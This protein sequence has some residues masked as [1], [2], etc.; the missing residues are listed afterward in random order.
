[1]RYIDLSLIDL[2]NPDVQNWLLKAQ[3]HLSALMTLQTHKERAEYFKTHGIWSDFKPNLVKL[4]GKKCWYSECLIEGD[5]GDVDHFRPKNRS[6]DASGKV[7]L[8]DGYWWLAYDYTNYRLSCSICNQIGK[9]DYFP[10][11]PGSQS[12][13]QGSTASEIP[14]LLDPCNKHDEILI[15]H[16][17]Q[18]S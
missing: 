4:C 17:L 1:M 6:L 15:L 3:Q 7:Q 18:L 2:N 12:G 16:S 13:N 5:Y 8:E 9:K 14:L 10:V 11:K